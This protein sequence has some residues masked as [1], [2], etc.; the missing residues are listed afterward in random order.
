MLVMMVP[1]L[2][3]RFAAPIWAFIAEIK[4]APSGQ[5]AAMARAYTFL[6]RLMGPIA[7]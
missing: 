3:K 4:M 7:N 6:I 2:R 1:P 5:D